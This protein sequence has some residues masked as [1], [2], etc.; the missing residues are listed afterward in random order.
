V[1]L[2]ADDAR[3][4]GHGAAVAA[5]GPQGA[6]DVVLLDDDGPIAIAQPRDGGLKP[7]VGFR[8]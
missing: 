8:A 7:V 6:A 5:Q 4:A 1:H 3:R 2:G